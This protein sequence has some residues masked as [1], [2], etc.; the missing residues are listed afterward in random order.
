MRVKDIVLA[1][2]SGIIL[3]VIFPKFNKEWL[4]WIALVPLLLAL[5]NKPLMLSF[6]LGW[7][8]GAI[9]F[10]GTLYWVTNTM[11]NYG[12]LPL[13]VSYLLLFLLVAYLGLYIGFFG[14]LLSYL[15]PRHL[16]FWSFFPPFLW[17]SLELARAY[18]LTGFPWA[19]LGYSQFQTLP[20]IQIADITG[21]YGVSF[22]IV[23]VNAVLAVLIIGLKEQRLAWGQTLLICLPPIL[24]MALS[25]GY[26]Q[27]V[28]SSAL[29][30]IK[31]N[32]AIKVAIIQGNI[33]Q[34]AKWDP[35][36]QDQVVA[37]Y[38]KLTLSAAANRPHLI[39][40]PETATPFFYQSD[41]HYS[42]E[43]G[44]LAYRTG[45][46]LLFGSPAYQKNGAIIKM[47]NRA[48]FIS[49]QKKSLGYYDKM[50]LVPFGEYVPLQ[51][52]LP[53][54]H[55]MVEGIGDFYRGDDY[56][57]MS[58]P[59]GRFSVLICFEIIFPHLVRQFVKNGAQ[60]LANITND[61]WFGRSAASYQHLSMGVFRAVENRVYII[62]SANT[63][64]SAFIDPEGNINQATELFVR[65]IIHGTIWPKGGKTTFYTY[66]GDLFA[67]LCSVLI[68][69]PL[70]IKIINI[71]FIR[72]KS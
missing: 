7:L 6:W 51:R 71:A 68:I 32:K 20:I 27:K 17:T 25:L 72:R 67:Y 62:R 53:F 69:I 11:V 29:P 15:V 56:T 10:G 14:L 31:K 43:I 8:T 60:F 18:F 59:Q 55:K 24:V 13:G 23:W 22:L 44:S 50:H 45:S 48:Y 19:S 38:K 65:A 28:K 5:W 30:P 36:Y 70:L 54:V 39:V 4:A 40:W 12:N 41:S 49:P 35:S 57:V 52:F 21:V 42:P 9:A 2:I 33:E 16:L 63:G 1:I 26:A 34:D 3:V 66:Y 64:I 46:Y 47:F 58:M 61:A 37:I